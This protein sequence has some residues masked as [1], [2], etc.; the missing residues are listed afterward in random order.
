MSTFVPQFSLIASISQGQQTTVTFT[1]DCDFSDGEIVSFRVSKEYGMRELNNVQTRV[2]EHT[3]DSI[4]VDI[5]SNNFTP[6]VFVSENEAVFP[7]MVVPA[8][9]G[10]IPN[11]RTAT[12]NLEDAFDNVPS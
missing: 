5:D 12:I 1:D 11:Q 7:A 9:S 2:I 4:T 3:S 8:G 6:F 10:I